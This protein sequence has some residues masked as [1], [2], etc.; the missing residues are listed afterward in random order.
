MSTQILIKRSTTA[1]SVPS[2]SDIATGEL[3]INTV[4]KRVFTNNQGTIVELGTYPSTQAVAGN[5]TVGGTLGVTGATTLSSGSVTGNWSVTGTLTVSTPTNTTDAARKDYVD[6]A[7][8]LK[9]SKAGDS[10]TGELA[11]GSNKITG[12]ATPTSS[13][14]AA[15]KGYVDAEVSAILDSAPAALDT[16]NELAA[17]IND[18]ANFAGT[19]TAALATKLPLAGGTMTGNIV[20]GANKVT[21]TATPTTA[22]DLSRKGYVDAQNALKV[23]KAGDT[24]T[25]NLVMGTNKV[26]TTANPTADDDLTRKGY[27]DGILGSAT[28][29]AT[30]ASEAAAS[31]TAAANSATASATSANTATTQA[32]AAS[33]SATN[34]ATSATNAGNSATSASNSATAAASSATAAAA[35]AANAA[36]AYDSFDDRYL[37]SKVSDPSVDNDGNALVTGAL[38]Y[39]STSGE[40]RV[41]DGSLWIA[42]SSASI[43]TMEK[44][45]FTATSGQTV[46]SGSDDSSRTLSLIAGV[47]IVTLNGIVLEADTDY[48]ATNSAITLATGATA[49]DELNV[50]A[51][52]NFQVADT[53]SKSLGGTF[54]GAVTMGG[55]LTVD[56]SVNISTNSGYAS[57]EMGGIDGAYIDLKAPF[58]EDYNGRL[59]WI[60]G[61]NGELRLAHNSS[62]AS[63]TFLT[64]NTERMRIDSN[65]NVGIGTSSPS[66]ALDVSGAIKFGASTERSILSGNANYVYIGQTNS[67]TENPES[68]SDYFFGI[69]PRM[70][71]DRRL[72]IESRTAD[73]S[74]AIV[75]KT[76]SGSYSTGAP[77]R[78]RID[79]AGR[80]T[81]PY[82]PA[83]MSYN[84]VT[85]NTTYNAGDF[86]SADMTA[87]LFNVGNCHSSS[88]GRFTA[89]VNGSYV[90]SMNLFNN[91]TSDNRRIRLYK[92]G[93]GITGGWGQGQFSAGG[94]A[95]CSTVVYLSAGDYIELGCVYDSTTLYQDVN[96]STFSGYLIG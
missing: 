34:A 12:L 95:A 69:N 32:S 50:Y 61:G 53:V 80:V 67:G 30:S 73:G 41:Y 58:S 16:L 39:N 22:D 47:E 44:F 45:K 3:A 88:T 72:D 14:D 89:P 25:G 57:L 93:V 66:K 48:T 36:S 91:T 71:A 6:S 81:M 62:T 13:T 42:A 17:A 11:M 37:G 5:A 40:M 24:M 92:N 23:A 8:A 4:D 20:M 35:S 54:T 68:A 79:S 63:T 90:F 75:F 55:G 76:G 19:V 28:S 43:E 52:G 15:T 82:Q 1:G 27:V 83:F 51:F 84:P 31:A 49:D 10:M 7:D 96:H 87:T 46:F 94:Q 60:E 2:T 78:M 56:N 77:E 18:D 64:N 74:G 70:G 33:T 26:T 85:S 21:S 59:Q 65:G 9:V 29:A 86:I 38:Y